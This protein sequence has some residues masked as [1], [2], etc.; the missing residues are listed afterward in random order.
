[1][2]GRDFYLISGA[3]AVLCILDFYIAKDGI[4]TVEGIQDLLNYLSNDDILLKEVNA[5]GVAVQRMYNILSDEKDY[6]HGRE[7]DKESD[8]ASGETPS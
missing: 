1:M 4:N 5:M 3:K 6:H 2:E 8:Q 7:M